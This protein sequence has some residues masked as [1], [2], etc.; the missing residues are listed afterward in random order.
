MSFG[1]G[2]H[3][4]TFSMI[5]LM[6]RID[7]KDKTVYDFGTGTGILAI[8]AEQLGAIKVLAVDNDDWCI[9]NAAENIQNNASKVISI[10]KVA[11]ALQKV[12]FDI[13]LAN[14]NRHIIE[15][16]M[17]ELTLASK[18]GGILILSGLLIDDQ[19]DMIVLANSKGWQLQEAQPL[20]GWISLLFNR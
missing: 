17:D 10:Q 14:V 16:N 18:P 12:Q 3:P 19:S 20:D 15:A 13:V 4:T 6:Q 2:H 9:E 7:F 8:L 1:T 5:Q 11:S